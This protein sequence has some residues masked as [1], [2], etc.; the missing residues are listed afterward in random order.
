MYC[1]SL[2]MEYTQFSVINAKKIAVSCNILALYSTYK[3]SIIV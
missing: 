1:H 3:G 2:F